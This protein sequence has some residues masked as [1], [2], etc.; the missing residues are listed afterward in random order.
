M[1]PSFGTPAQEWRVYGYDNDK[2][3]IL[4]NRAT[5][6]CL[7]DSGAGLRTWPCNG[8]D[9]QNWYGVDAS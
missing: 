4:Q 2:G 5:G 7:D 8:M 1:R 6:R 9:F 3:H